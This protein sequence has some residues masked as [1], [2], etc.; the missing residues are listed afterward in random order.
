MKKKL[1]LVEDEAII[2]L[3]EK[4]M[5]QKNGYNVEVCNTGEEAIEYIKDNDVDL[6]LMDIN[7]GGGLTGPQAARK[8]LKVKNVPIVFLSSHTEKEIVDKVKNIT[9]Y[10]Y[11]VKNSGEFVLIESIEM[12]FSL[13]KAHKEAKGSELKYEQLFNDAPVGIFRTTS[14][15]KVIRVNKKFADL[16]EYPNAEDLHDIDDLPHRFYYHPE[17]RY[18]FISL[19]E[20]YGHVENFEFQALTYNGDPKWVSI[21][22]RKDEEYDDY[23]IIDGY[24]FDISGTREVNDKIRLAESRF[25]NLF[26]EMHEGVAVYRSIN[27]GENFEFVDL[28]EAGERLSSVNK[29]DVIGKKVTEVFPSIMSDEFDLFST[30]Q[31]VYQTGETKHH[32]LTLYKDDRVQQWV[33]NTVYKLNNGELVALYRDTTEQRRVEDDLMKSEERYRTIFHDSTTPMMLIRPSTGEIVDVNGAATKLYGWSKEELLNMRIVDINKMSEDNVKAEMKKAEKREKNVFQFQHTTKNGEVREV[34]VSS[35]PI[36]V[37]GEELLYSIIIDY[38]EQKRAQEDLIKSEENLKITLDSI[39]DAVITTDNNKIITDVNPVAENLLG[40]S[41]EEAIG[42]YIDDIFYIFNVQTEERVVNPINEVLKTGEIVLLENHTKLKAKDGT[43]YHIADSAAPIKRHGDE[44]IGVVL[45]F[46]DVTSTYE[47]RQLLKQAVEDK[48]RLMSE[49]THRIKNNLGL[50]RSLIEL[51]ARESNENFID[52]LSQIDAIQIVHE[53]LQNVNG[54]ADIN[55]TNYT[56]QLLEAIFENFTS[57]YVEIINDTNDIR[58]DSKRTVSLGLIL[59][60]LATN[61]IKHGFNNKEDAKFYVGLEEDE[62]YTLTISSTGNS[63]PEEVDFDNL[64]GLGLRIVESLVQQLKGEMS[65]NREK[66]IFII[67]FPK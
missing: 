18:E 16:V 44:I 63:I 56:Q 35:G 19:L 5:L 2:A 24:M 30:F 66:S 64:K 40:Y 53:K 52:V 14:N 55:I 51:K 42:Q 12:A 60:E 41:K 33:E 1:M 9:N 49:I 13:H 27:N 6:I 46:R 34:E 59:N 36:E 10:G 38:T 23:F 39:G 43:E 8:I 3:N 25:R 62:N 45:V 57:R 28:N 20:E 4:L 31:E 26:N 11:V 48:K 61:A 15:G 22:A 58:L 37:R 32:P 29:D 7:L 65:I 17:K 50:V 54:S 67:T 21:N 47:E